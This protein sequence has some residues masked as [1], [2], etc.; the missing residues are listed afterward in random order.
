MSSAVNTYEQG[1]RSLNA[2]SEQASKAQAKSLADTLFN[3]GIA[4][5]VGS[6]ESK[7]NAMLGQ[8]MSTGDQ[9][10]AN[11]FLN[12]SSN[13]KALTNPAGAGSRAS[14]KNI[15]NRI[16]A[17]S[18]SGDGLKEE[19]ADLGRWIYN[20]KD[21]RDNDLLDLLD[22]QIDLIGSSSSDNAIT[23]AAARLKQINQM[24]RDDTG[25]YAVDF[26]VSMID[27]RP[28]QQ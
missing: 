9:V 24:A 10:V 4:E 14:L 12:A 16:D 20:Q 15:K 28:D 17:I 18:R 3:N 23:K 11:L 26:Y 19:C 2:A 1:C 22:Q 21:F 13:L 7:V 5:W 8:R 25:R 6:L 27:S